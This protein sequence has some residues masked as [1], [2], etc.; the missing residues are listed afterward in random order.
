MSN[1]RWD[2]D[3][4]FDVRLLQDFE[5]KLGV[6]FPK[7]YINIVTEHDSSQPEVLVDGN[8][9]TGLVDIEYEYKKK[10]TFMWYSYIGDFKI[11]DAYT[12]T[13]RVVPRGLIPFADNGAGNVYYFD[14]RDSDNPSI[15]YQEH[16]EV[17]DENNVTEDEL[18][19]ANLEYWQ[20]KTLFHVA[21][22]FVEFIQMIY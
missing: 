3:K 2:T 16:E 5:F 18:E 15:K 17:V 20:D 19:E 8:W 22:N 10:D 12:I 1:L 7:E 21:N 14:F 6:K 11:T 9:K 13:R 4:K